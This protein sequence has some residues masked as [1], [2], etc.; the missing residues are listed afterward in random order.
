M[1]IDY[2]SVNARRAGVADLPSWAPRGVDPDR[3]NIARVYDYW[4]GGTHNFSADQ[5]VARALIS[6]EPQ[7]RTIAR[8]NRA[9]LRRSVRYLAAE[10]GV[11]QFL[12]I[13]SGIP[14]EGNVHEIAQ[15]AAPGPGWCTSTSTRWPSRTAS[16]SWPGTRTP[17]SSRA[18]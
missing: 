6:V 12:D 8:C 3:A 2:V 4:L 7:I 16:R 1:A 15:A 14:T 17:P 11:R 18:T 13:G 10:A 9:F 5:D